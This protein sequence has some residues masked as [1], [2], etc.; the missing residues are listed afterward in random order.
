MQ[1]SSS[2]IDPILETLSNQDNLDT[3]PYK[4]I[5][6]KVNKKSNH[7]LEPVKGEIVSNLDELRKGSSNTKYILYYLRDEFSA[8]PKS[9]IDHI[10]RQRLF[11][12]DSLESR[13]L[14]DE[15]DK[16]NTL[17]DSIWNLELLRNDEH[18]KKQILKV[19]TIK[20]KN[21]FG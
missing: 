10:F 2:W 3:F 18:K 12:D 20:M 17:K 5:K 4:E 6:E 21:R 8:D 9:Q 7:R 14:L 15:K 13:G 1:S 19:K 11:E 16:Y